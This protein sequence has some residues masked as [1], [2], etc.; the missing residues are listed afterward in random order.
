MKFIETLP[1]LISGA[2]DKAEV[3]QKTAQDS[4]AVQST[5][6]FITIKIDDRTLEQLLGEFKEQQFRGQFLQVSVARESFLEKLKREREE[7]NEFTAKKSKEATDKSSVADVS[8]ELP[9]FK[10]DIQSDDESSSES[11]EDDE[12]VVNKSKFVGVKGNSRYFGSDQE[13]E[14]EVDNSFLRKKSKRFL[15]NGKV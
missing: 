7:A 14:V 1:L 9:S 2:V 4:T 13:E 15:E 8:G 11:S 10:A 12:P 5:F 3:K 6:A